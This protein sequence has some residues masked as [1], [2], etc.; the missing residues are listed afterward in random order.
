MSRITSNFHFRIF[1]DYH[2]ST[3]HQ[4]S[5]G[6]EVHFPVSLTHSLSLSRFRW[7]LFSVT[8]WLARWVFN[9]WPQKNALQHNK[10]TKV[11][12]KFCQIQNKQAK[13]A[14]CF[15]KFAKVEFCQIWSHW[16][17]SEAIY[18]K[19]LK[20]LIH[21]GTYLHRHRINAIK[22]ATFYFWKLSSS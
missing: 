6:Q 5:E 19:N 16:F 1:S 14:N 4:A 11:C 15:E 20:R 22:L 17:Y 9:I 7:I 2:F 18:K 8:R 13:I 12:W 10:C 3:G 21:K